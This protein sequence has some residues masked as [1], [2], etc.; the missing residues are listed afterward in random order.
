MSR[1]PK[2]P[3]GLLVFECIVTLPGIGRGAEHF[4]AQ[5]EYDGNLKAQEE[6]NNE[7]D[8]RMRKVEAVISGLPAWKDET[9]N[10]IIANKRSDD[11][12]YAEVRRCAADGGQPVAFPV[13]RGWVP[14][15]GLV[16]H[17]PAGNDSNC[18]SSNEGM[19]GPL[20]PARRTMQGTAR[21]GAES[22]GKQSRT[23]P[24]RAVLCFSHL[25]G[26]AAWV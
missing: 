9:V 15:A 17:R 4:A 18:R 7:W 19:P 3:E 21:W 11:Q 25:L 5:G 22:V 14:G 26:P 8:K 23:H 12:R 1:P 16:S 2:N 24:K 13:A 20:V 10:L 6:V